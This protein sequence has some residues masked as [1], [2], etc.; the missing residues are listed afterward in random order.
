MSIDLSN[1]TELSDK[2]GVITQIADASGRVIWAVKNDVPIVLGVEKITSNTY[3]GSTAYNNEQFILLSIYP[4]TASSIVNITYGNLT[5][6]L[7]FSGTNSQQVY[8]G[9]FNGVSDEV[10]TPASGEL[11]IEGDYAGFASGSFN[12][13][14]ST[15][16]VRGCITEVINFGKVSG[17]SQGAFRE[18]RKLENISIPDGVAE[19]GDSAFF[20][21]TSLKTISIPKSTNDIGDYPMPRIM[22]VPDTFANCTALRSITVD[23]ANDTFSAEDGVLFNRNKTD[24]V[25]YPGAS[26]HYTIPKTVN[27]IW[28]GAFRGAL[29]TSVTIHDGVTHIDTGAFY[30][31]GLT[32]ITIPNSVTEVETSLFADC[33]DLT[34]VNFPNSITKIQRYCFSNCTSLTEITIPNSVIGIESY[35]FDNC[36]ALTSVTFENTSGWYVTETQNGDVSTGTAV[37]VSDPVANVAFVTDTYKSHY[38]YRS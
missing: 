21:C 29:L 9:T 3:V 6:T 22:G 18:C 1:V 27:R 13:A 19:I 37:D 17:I 26:G 35:A 28:G 10:E 25:A 5:K 24:L 4:K 16:E 33:A 20:N 12:V 38:W 32:E 11:T 30:N 34:R 14:K 2:Y 23:P 31:T 7:T 36:S 15:P 8:F